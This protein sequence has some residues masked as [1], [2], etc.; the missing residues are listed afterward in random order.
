MSDALQG[1]LSHKQEDASRSRVR[2]RNESGFGKDHDM[3]RQTGVHT[4][5]GLGRIVKAT[6]QAPMEISVGLTKG[7]HNLPKLWG[8]DTVRPQEQI[9]DFKSGAMAA[10]KEF[11]FG[12]YDGITGL[13]TQPW[14]GAQKEGT[15][16]FVKGIGKGIAGF[17]TKPFTGFSGIISHTTKGVHKEVQ[18]LFGSSV[19]NYIVTSRVA[20]GYE[21]WLQSSDAEKQDVIVQWKLIQKYPKKK[22]NPDEIVQGVL[23]AQRKQNIE[24]AKARQ[25]CG[26]TASSAQSSSADALTLDP[27]GAILAM[28]GSQSPEELLKAAEV[29]QTIPLSIQ[30]TSRRNAEDDTNMEWAIQETVSQLQSQQQEPAD[31]QAEQENMRQ[32]IASSETEVQRDASEAL[33][34]KKQ[35]KQA[36]AQSLREQRHRGNDSEW[37]SDIGLNDEDDDGFEQVIKKS[38]NM[39]GKAAAVTGRSPG[40]QQPS[41]YNPG[42]LAGT[43]QSEFEAQQQGL[44]GGK[45]TQERMEEKIVMEYAKKQSLLEVHYQNKGKGRATAIE[46]KDDEDLQ[47]ALK[48]SMQGHEY[49]VEY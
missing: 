24:D 23:E 38:E 47:K 15:S 35:L 30:E 21:E 12:W 41:L 39:A 31:H 9:S 40:V 36:M 48:L 42:H 49:D 1:Q 25:N 33:E 18:K 10:G 37:E 14:K 6:V 16:G 4:S 46:D 20:Q 11:G 17:A 45:T 29:N 7:F 26:H 2:S 3:L 27:E 19:Q 13:V 34:Y 32:A 22:H 43:T 44:W 28:G 8:D 5:K